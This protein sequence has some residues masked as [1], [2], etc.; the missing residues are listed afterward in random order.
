MSCRSEWPLLL[1]PELFCDTRQMMWSVGLPLA[2]SRGCL[3]EF[4]GLAA[5]PGAPPGE[6]G[7][8]V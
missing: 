8:E 6:P 7:T 4:V 5:W 1:L 3:L 2:S